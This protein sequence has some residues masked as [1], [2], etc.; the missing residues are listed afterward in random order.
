MD[1]NPR[2]EKTRDWRHNDR[3]GRAWAGDGPRAWRRCPPGGRLEE[4]R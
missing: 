2:L 4:K 3:P 1:R